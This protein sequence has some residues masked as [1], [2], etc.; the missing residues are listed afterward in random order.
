MPHADNTPRRTSRSPNEHDQS[1]VE[2]AGSY[3]PWLT[4]VVTLVL[5]REMR[6][7]EYFLCSAQI[8]TAL[9]QSRRPLIGIAGNAHALIV[10]THNWR[11][12]DRR[13]Q[14]ALRPANVKHDD[15]SG[16]STLLAQGA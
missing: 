1:S 16:V 9:L 3:K 11:V 8:Q 6:P 7:G 4:V 14:R 2:P 12:N 10:A 15:H 5:T 13:Y